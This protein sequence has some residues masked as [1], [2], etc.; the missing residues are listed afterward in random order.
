MNLSLGS[1][2]AAHKCH[3]ICL[4]TNYWF[5]MKDIKASLVAQMVKYL[6]PMQ[7]TQVQSLGWGDLLKKGMA[8]YSSILAWRISWTEE[9][10]RVRYN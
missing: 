6:P 2:P 1:P 8:T 4:L 10:Q 5:I 7:K 9:S 3:K